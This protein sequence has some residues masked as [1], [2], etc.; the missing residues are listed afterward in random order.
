MAPV[1]EK[2]TRKRAKSVIEMPVEAEAVAASPLPVVEAIPLVEPALHDAADEPLAATSA[3]E[4]TVPDA[5]APVDLVVS[6][7]PEPNV[8]PA[9]PAA[10]AKKEATMTETYTT[11]ADAMKNGAEAMKA[12]IH[13]TTENAMNQGKAAFDQVAS[14]SREAIE[15]GMKQVD[16]FAG[17]A[18]GN[19]EA[20]L[21]SSRAAAQGIEAIAREIAEF[22]RKA[23]DETTA[24]ARAMTTV[25][26]P[27]E[28]LQLQNDFA[29]TQF[30]AAVAEMSK[31]SETMVKLMGEVFEPMQARVAVATD[32]MKAMVGTVGQ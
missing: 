5:S 9:A 2:T 15:H 6:A 26:T 23:F 32:K 28:L 19:V 1:E 14:K 7:D 4:L 21:A 27:N 3:V 29:K 20:M 31:L 16:E 10:E 12:S 8:P 30:D 24:A 17:M 22:N 11:A 18:R 25:K 13:T